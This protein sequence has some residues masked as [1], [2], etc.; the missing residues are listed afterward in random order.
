MHLSHKEM[1][2]Y[3]YSPR[4]V[5]VRSYEK[6]IPLMKRVAVTRPSTKPLHAAVKSKAKA[7]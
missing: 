1:K 7:L 4:F 5:I 6:G 2:D 3:M